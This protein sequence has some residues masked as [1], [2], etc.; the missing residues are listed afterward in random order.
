MR[1]IWTFE[2]HILGSNGWTRTDL[3]TL[4]QLVQDKALT[5]VIDCILPLPE[6]REAVRLLEEREVIGKVIVVPALSL[7]APEHC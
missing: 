4:L 2:L 6:A 7:R 5:P 1:Y 3:E